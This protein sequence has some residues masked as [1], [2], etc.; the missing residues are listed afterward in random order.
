MKVIMSYFDPHV[1]DSDIKA[2]GKRYGRE[3]LSFNSPVMGSDKISKV[4]PQDETAQRV[5]KK[6]DAHR[7]FTD[8]LDPTHLHRQPVL[9]YSA[10]TKR[11]K[12]GLVK[13]DQLKAMET[14]QGRRVAYL[15]LFVA[16]SILLAL[17]A[18]TASN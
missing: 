11:G 17:A 2:V 15:A 4:V 18:F 7:I 14:Q 1:D 10:W 3:L 16:L 9:G 12:L 6:M 8:D 5:L 13:A